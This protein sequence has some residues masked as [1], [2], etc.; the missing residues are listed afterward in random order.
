MG[1]TDNAKSAFDYG[2]K[3]IFLRKEIMKEWQKLLL[4]V[5]IFLGAYY[6]P[7]DATYPA[8]RPGG[9]YDASGV[10]SPTSIDVSD[11]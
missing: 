2:E 5:A 8:V 9:L 6:I 10:C 7:W 11:S 3:I 1:W 4:I